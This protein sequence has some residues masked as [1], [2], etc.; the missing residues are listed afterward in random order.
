QLTVI[1]LEKQLAQIIDKH[2]AQAQARESAAQAAADAVAQSPIASS[3]L[4]L[5]P[6]QHGSDESHWTADDDERGAID[7]A[8]YASFAS[9]NIVSHDRTY[10]SAAG[11]KP[12]QFNQQAPRK[13]RYQAPSRPSLRS[14]SAQAI[15]LLL[16]EPTHA[17]LWPDAMLSSLNDPETALLCTLAQALREAPERSLAALLGSWHGRAEGEALAAIAATESLLP[18]ADSTLEAVDLSHRLHGRL[19]EQR[20]AT[21]N[22]ALQESPSKENLLAL[23]QAKRELAQWMQQLPQAPSS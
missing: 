8:Y 2:V 5:P 15:R 19:L 7:E 6:S 10:S 4:P 17:Q 14:L 22:S 13:P 21:I 9:A 11:R 20:I 1:V 3:A 12:G 18:D 16:R 23:T